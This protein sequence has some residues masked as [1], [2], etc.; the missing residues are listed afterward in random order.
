[1]A[2][3]I[4]NVQATT[5]RTA[6]NGFGFGLGLVGAVSL[7]GMAAGVS[8]VAAGWCAKNLCQAAWKAM[9]TGSGFPI[10]AFKKKIISGAVAAAATFGVAN[11]PSA[12]S[13]TNA[14]G[15]L[16]PTLLALL[17]GA[18]AYI[19]TD[20]REATSGRPQAARSVGF[21]NQG[22]RPPRV[23]AQPKPVPEDILD[24]RFLNPVEFQANGRY[25]QFHTIAAACQYYIENIEN[26]P[27]K[28]VAQVAYNAF[29]N[30]PTM[31]PTSNEEL[32]RVPNGLGPALVQAAA[33]AYQDSR[34]HPT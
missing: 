2:V 30:N 5:P 26:N 9:P 12:Q 28:A 8:L 22:V 15:P 34:Q 6:L 7:P 11:I 29:C 13:V 16:I 19:V 21:Q 27:Q 14:V 17:G 24:V 4:P 31:I 23:G 18:V 3:T 1:M 32:L 20:V 25:C 10:A 33:K